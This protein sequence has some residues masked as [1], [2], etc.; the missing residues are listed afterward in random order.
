MEFSSK[1]VLTEAIKKSR[2]PKMALDGAKLLLNGGGDYPDIFKTVFETVWSDATRRNQAIERRAGKNRLLKW[3]PRT[4]LEEGAC[5]LVAKKVRRSRN[6]EREFGKVLSSYEEQ[7]I[8][9][10]YQ[11]L[12]GSQ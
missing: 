9:R 5:Q 8:K 7:T 4:Q 6:P 2:S 11:I 1:E 10:I 3:P 12:S